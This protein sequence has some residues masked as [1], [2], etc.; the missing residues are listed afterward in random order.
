[1][2]VFKRSARSSSCRSLKGLEI[3]AS[4]LGLPTNGA[5]VKSAKL[6]HDRRGEYCKVLGGV[7]PVDTSA[8]DIRFEVNLPTNWNHKAVQFGG[9]TFDGWL[10][11]PTSGLKR[12][13]V[14]VASDPVPL[15]RGYATF[16]GDSGHHKCYFPLPDALEHGE[17]LVCQEC[18]GAPQLCA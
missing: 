2:E 3:P 6:V 1:M 18:R 5:Y 14:G 11:G 17:C 10:G 16:G 7:R 15:A 12:G 8:Q 9:G 4:G 13:P